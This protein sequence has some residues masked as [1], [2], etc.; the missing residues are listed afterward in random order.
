MAERDKPQPPL[1]GWL[2]FRPAHCP[3]DFTRRDRA[4][5]GRAPALPREGISPKPPRAFLMNRSDKTGRFRARSLSG[6]C[7]V[8]AVMQLRNKPTRTHLDPALSLVEC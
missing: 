7:S 6:R 3:R 2:T 4:H 8:G 1:P 5:A